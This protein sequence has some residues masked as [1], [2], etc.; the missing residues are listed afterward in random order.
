MCAWGINYAK[1]N[2]SFGAEGKA[3]FN[4]LLG[5]ISPRDIELKLVKSKKRFMSMWERGRKMEESDILRRLI[6]CGRVHGF[7][8][9]I[10]KAKGYF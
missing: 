8:G 6:F 4:Q 2:H 5:A 10:L 3:E 7:I 9:E 1:K